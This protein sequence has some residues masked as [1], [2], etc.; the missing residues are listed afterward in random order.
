MP[1]IRYQSVH[2]AVILLGS[3]SL[4]LVFFRDFADI[5]RMRLVG[6]YK[7]R[8]FPPHDHR[9]SPKVFI[10]RFFPV[11]P[12]IAQIHGSIA[13]LTHPADAGGKKM[14]DNPC[15]FQGGK[16]QI[17]HPPGNIPFQDFARPLSFDALQIHIHTMPFYRNL[18]KKAFLYQSMRR[19]FS[20]PCMATTSYRMALSSPIPWRY[21]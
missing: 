14:A 11:P 4:S 17:F 1:L 9:D 12:R 13:P 19:S 21:R 18:W 3:N 7:I 15:L 2:I 20:V 10:H 16:R 8:N 6:Q 5:R